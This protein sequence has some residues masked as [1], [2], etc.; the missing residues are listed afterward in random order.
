MSLVNS[1]KD[2]WSVADHQKNLTFR[3]IIKT[4][5]SRLLHLSRLNWSLTEPLGD[6]LAVRFLDQMLSNYRTTPDNER[7]RIVRP[8]FSSVKNVQ[9][10]EKFDQKIVIIADWVSYKDSIS[11]KILQHPL[12]TA[13]F[14]F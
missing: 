5:F 12:I 1:P 10:M 13:Q 7:G 8:F 6:E 3:I 14:K 9:K 2:L 4:S 11:L